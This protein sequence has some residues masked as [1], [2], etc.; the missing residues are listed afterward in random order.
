[1]VPRAAGD[2]MSAIHVTLRQPRLY[3]PRRPKKKPELRG[4][5]PP[6]A[7][8]PEISIQNRERSAPSPRRAVRRVGA[9]RLQGGAAVLPAE[10]AGGPGDV[11][12]LGMGAVPATS[13]GSNSSP[14]AHVAPQTA[15]LYSAVPVPYK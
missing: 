15:R 7:R 3:R 1:V 9:P 2:F 4:L 13:V 14:G 11:P 5:C 8:T 10:I 12:E 6:E